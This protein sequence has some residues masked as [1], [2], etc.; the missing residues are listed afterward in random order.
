MDGP[1]ARAGGRAAATTGGSSRSPLEHGPDPAH[2]LPRRD[3]ADP[4]TRPS[5]TSGWPRPRWPRPTAGRWASRSPAWAARTSPPVGSRRRSTTAARPR[6][7]RQPHH[8]P[9]G[10][11]HERPRPSPTSVASTRRSAWVDEPAG[12]LDHVGPGRHRRRQDPAGPGAVP[13]VPSTCSIG[14]GV[15]PVRR[16]RLRGRPAHVRRAAGRGPR[17][18]GTDQRRRR[19]PARGAGRPGRDRRP[20]RHPGRLPAAGRPVAS[21]SWPPP[22]HR[23]KAPRFPGSGPATRARRRRRWCSRRASARWTTPRVVLATAAT[24]ARR[25]RIDRALTWSAAHPRGRVR[26]RTARWWPSPPGLRP[27]RPCG[28]GRP[29]PWSGPSGTT[30]GREAFVDRTARGPAP[31]ARDD[32]GRGQGAVPR[33]RRAG[34]PVTASARQAPPPPTSPSPG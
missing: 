10:H 23:R 9:P 8:P 4:R 25:L 14:I 27:P 18:S 21:T 3:H 22:S 7:H 19:R 11:P 32:P 6:A 16:R 13:R 24:L 1:P 33:P 26:R 20:P 31:R 30:A 28:P 5:A 2:G 15:Q 17:R 12:H 29:P 34:R